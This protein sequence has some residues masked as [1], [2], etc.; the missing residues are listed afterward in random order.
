PFRFHRPDDCLYPCGVGQ[1]C[2]VQLGSAVEVSE[3][4]GPPGMPADPDQGVPARRHQRLD[5]VAADEPVNPGNQD[6]HGWGGDGVV[7][8]WAEA[9]PPP[10]DLATSLDP[11]RLEVRTRLA[12]EAGQVGPHHP[13][14]ELLETHLR[15]PPEL[16]L[17]LARVADEQVDLG[18]A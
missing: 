17:R 6:T 12:L 16:R 4:R 2:C 1:L 5:E 11:S 3:W 13:L 8:W 14:H 15:L 18:R 10:R 7:G 9:V